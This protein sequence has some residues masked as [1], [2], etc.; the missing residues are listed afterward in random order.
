MEFWGH[1]ICHPGC[2]KSVEF[3]GGFLLPLFYLKKFFEKSIILLMYVD[4]LLPLSDI[5]QFFTI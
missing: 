2:G 3:S 5:F 4:F 1:R